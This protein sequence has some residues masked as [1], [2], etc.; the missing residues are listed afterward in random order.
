[1]TDLQRPAEVWQLVEQ[2]TTDPEIEILNPKTARQSWPK[3]P[4]C[5]KQSDAISNLNFGKK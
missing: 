1:M 4:V 5:Q 3:L 2:P